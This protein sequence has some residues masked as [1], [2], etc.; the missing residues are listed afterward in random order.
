MKFYVDF[1]T[2][3]VTKIDPEALFYQSNNL[4]NTI[5]IYLANCGIDYFLSLEF[6]RADNRKYSLHTAT[7]ISS[8]EVDGVTYAVHTFVLTDL[9]L[10][11]AGTLGFTSYMN[12]TNVDSSTTPATVTLIGRGALFNGV[13]KVVKTAGFT[14]DSLLV[15]DSGQTPEEI[16]QSILND[17]LR[18]NGLVNNALAGVATNAAN[19][20]TN[21]A[22]I[23]ANEI[24]V[25]ETSGLNLA[26]HIMSVKIKEKC[27]FTKDSYGVF[28][29]YDDREICC[30]K[31]GN[32]SLH[33]FCYI[34]PV[35]Q[36]TYQNCF[37]KTTTTTDEATV[38]TYT[39]TNEAMT[40]LYNN[41]YKTRNR[42][43]GGASAGN[44][45]TYTQFAPRTAL[46]FYITGVTRDFFIDILHIF[47][48]SISADSLATR[49]VLFNPVQMQVSGMWFDAEFEYNNKTYL[50]SLYLFRS[51][52]NT[53][54]IVIRTD[55][56]TGAVTS[57]QIKIICLS[58]IAANKSNIASLQSEV[59]AIKDGTTLD[60]FADVEGA[61]DN[62]DDDISALQTQVNNLSAVQNVVDVVATKAALDALTTT[63]IEQYDKVQ[64]I[65]DETHDG[66]ST[67]YEWTGSAWEYVGAYGGNCYT[68]IQSDTLLNG[69]QNVID[70]NHKLSSDLI[71]DTNEFS[72]HKFVSADEKIEVSRL[73]SILI[74]KNYNQT[75]SDY[76]SNLT[77]VSIT[78]Y[79]SQADW[80]SLTE[81]TSVTVAL[82]FTDYTLA[83]N[84]RPQLSTVQNL[85]VEGFNFRGTA[86]SPVSDG[87]Y[88]IEGSIT[89][90]R[91][92]TFTFRGFK[93]YTEAEVNAL[94]SSK[95]EK[96]GHIEL[97]GSFGEVLSLSDAQITELNKPEAII[98]LTDIGVKCYKVYDNVFISIPEV[99]QND[100]LEDMQIDAF[101]VVVNFTNKECEIFDNSGAVYTSIGIDNTKV[102]SKTYSELATL[103]ANGDLVPGQ[104]YR[105]TDYVTKTNGTVNGNLGI[106]RSAEHPFDIIVTATSA[107]TLSEEAFAVQ[108]SGDSYFANS[109]LSV[110]KLWYCLDNDSTRFEWADTS[111]GK[112]VI[113]RM[114]DEFGNDLPYDFKNIQFKRYKITAT[115]DSRQ[116]S[117]VGL[118]LGVEG[119]YGCTYDSSDFVWRYTFDRR[120]NNADLS[121]TATH[122]STIANSYYVKEVV[123]GT[124]LTD[125]GAYRCKQALN[126][127]VITSSNIIIDVKMGT[128]SCFNTWNGNSDITY[129]YFGPMCRKN[130]M[131]GE[132]VHV[133]ARECFQE[134]IIGTST[135][136]DNAFRWMRCQNHFQKNI[137]IRAES[138]S[139]ETSTFSEN[140]LPGVF[141][142]NIVSGGKFSNNNFGNLSTLQNCKLGLMQYCTFAGSLFEALTITYLYDCDINISNFLGS[143]IDREEYVD[144][145]QGSSSYNIMNLT[146]ESMFGTDSTHITIPL[147]DLTNAGNPCSKRLGYA[148]ARSQ[149]RVLVYTWEEVDD[150]RS[151][152]IVRNNSGKM[153]SA[154]KGSTWVEISSTDVNEIHYSDVAETQDADDKLRIT[155]AKLNAAIKN[156]ELLTVNET[157]FEDFSQYS[158]LYY[159][160]GGIT[161]IIF[162]PETTKSSG[163]KYVAFGG[164]HNTRITL[165]FSLYR[166]EGEYLID[167]FTVE[168]LQRVYFVSTSD[169]S[170]DNDAGYLYINDIVLKHLIMYG[171]VDLQ[172]DDDIFD[173]FQDYDNI[174]DI[175]YDSSVYKLE[176]ADIESGTFYYLY[177]DG[178]ALCPMSLFDDN[179][180]LYIDYNVT[181]TPIG[182]TLKI[183]HNVSGH[184][185]KSNTDFYYNL[186]LPGDSED[187]SFTSFDDVVKK[188]LEVAPNIEYPCT[189]YIP[190]DTPTTNGTV[191]TYGMINSI[192][193]H[194]QN[195]NRR[196]TFTWYHADTNGLQKHTSDT[197][198]TGGTTDDITDNVYLY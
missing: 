176:T 45:Y 134:N 89:S 10:A 67:I 68:K 31:D 125:N 58:D 21:A 174:Y 180:R 50:I 110:W 194:I 25:S 148:K 191:T 166:D 104:Y 188:L 145:T 155:N 54:S 28:V 126:D 103:K 128:D 92:Y 151:G 183:Q 79:I 173:G 178:L 112:G 72:D 131:S 138:S 175:M 42:G 63:N 36:S 137:V 74:E 154:D 22:N 24:R 108:H 12:Y 3:Q 90:D 116:N 86:N 81:R 106:A 4:T 132:I 88:E 52:Q 23:A 129:N 164:K 30:D 73:S 168:P 84:L 179:D 59:N 142:G 171:N 187:T 122:Q 182:P 139:I 141:K 181:F 34:L 57:D 37:T 39:F 190:I 13:N 97:S 117:L 121:L 123:I 186:T 78:G 156:Q 18:L 91:E 33:P 62:V 56:V 102:I 51:N 135:L 71:D 35:N 136:S 153:I 99:S 147:S 100:S 146:V 47:D 82:N 75:A 162:Y 7:D 115:T 185:T 76:L 192:K 95:Q 53:A 101:S 93:V 114:I 130:I 127:I 41:E 113:Y 149:N 94:L 64:V 61:I 197:L 2:K 17:I 1:Q 120:S 70:S 66:A 109:D 44:Y 14:A 172:F 20:A 195:S 198:T 161:N 43:L 119:C 40:K 9:I 170:Y 105:I 98:E 144:I 157:V 48:P 85:I 111:N 152:F 163:T 165:T 16:E 96:F 150:S 107:N 143:K 87:M 140:V 8:E 11:V 196:A 32:L 46:S 83:F 15:L 133:N 167:E 26:N 49:Q 6:L 193:A 69:K 184:F 160:L 118:Y 124:Y 158:L 65:A 55:A 5:S 169:V 177:N 77:E 159:A 80:N 27:G 60:S 189:G 29:D 19:I 38:N